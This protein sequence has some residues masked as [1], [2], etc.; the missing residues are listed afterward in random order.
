MVYI[1]NGILLSH[2]KEQNNAICGKVDGTRDSRTKWSKLERERQI[3]HDIT[4]IWNQIYGTMKLSTEKKLRLREQTWGFQ[5]GGGESGMD[6]EFGVSRC[7][8]LHLE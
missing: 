8:L 7:K 3:P 2:K 5:G 4:H 6:S 1:R